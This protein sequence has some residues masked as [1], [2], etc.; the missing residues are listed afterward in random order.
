[1]AP[2]IID[3]DGSGT[4]R[5]M[6]SSMMLPKPWQVGHAP[7]GL[8]NENSRGCGS[9]YIRP[10]GRHSKRSENLSTREASAVDCS[11]AHAAPP[12]SRYAVSMESVNR[13]RMSDPDDSRDDPSRF[14]G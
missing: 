9:S 4:T 1:M 14:E 3:F 13:W 7:N 11:I 8:L 12:P 6:S 2:C 5:S 10:H